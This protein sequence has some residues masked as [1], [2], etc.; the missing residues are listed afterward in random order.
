ME[1]SLFIRRL[2]KNERVSFIDG[3]KRNMFYKNLK[4]VSK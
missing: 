4:I 3:D 1:A 2:E